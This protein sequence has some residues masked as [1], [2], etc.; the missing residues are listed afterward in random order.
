MN[1]SRELVEA[2]FDAELDASSGSRW[3]STWRLAGNAPDGTSAWRNNDPAF[4]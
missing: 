2:F 3:P 1:C 4:G